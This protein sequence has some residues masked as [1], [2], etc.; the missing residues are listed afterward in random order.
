MDVNCENTTT[1]GTRTVEPEFEG[2]YLAMDIILVDLCLISCI[3]DG[4]NNAFY[5]Y[6]GI[7]TVPMVKK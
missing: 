5:Q 1:K 7:I 2:A 3:V 4:A 6:P